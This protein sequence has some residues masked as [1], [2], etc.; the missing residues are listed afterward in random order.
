[1]DFRDIDLNLFRIFY[2]VYR[3]GSFSKAAENLGITQPSI[4]Y[5]VKNLEQKIGVKLFER[6]GYSSN[7]TMEA[8]ILIPYIE[9][10]LN[11]IDLGISSVNDFVNLNRGNIAIGVPSH[12]GVFFLASIIKQFNTI[13]PNIKIKVISKPTKELFRLL[14]N[15]ELD[16]VIDSSPLDDNIYKFNIKK[17]SKEK[18]A[19][20]CN[21]KMKELFERKIK[22]T[23]LLKYPL[24]VP[25]KT[26]GSTK[27]LMK[28]FEKN[29]LKFEPSFEIATSDMI[30][31]LL[32]EN[33]GIGY[34]FEKTIE[35]YP[36]LK[37]IDVDVSLPTFDIYVIH[38]EKVVSIPTTEFIKFINSNR[39]K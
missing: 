29:N 7:L 4:S 23:E 12:I 15:N 26:S 1:M 36:N 5:S 38:K 37:K 9:Q 8:E 31:Q 6:T 20:A 10:A 16:V 24:I 27:E 11:S 19:F 13:H 18:C 14:N 17:I 2:T 30:V 35:T 39:Y 21:S 33:L 25:S 22:M 34:L 28:V 32:E 3:S